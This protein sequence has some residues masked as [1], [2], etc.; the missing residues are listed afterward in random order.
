M[1]AA[2]GKKVADRRLR[3]RGRRAP[4]SASRRLIRQHQAAE[5][6]WSQ[7]VKESLG[8]GALVSDDGSFQ[9][10]RQPRSPTKLAS[11]SN[12][13]TPKARS[14]AGCVDTVEHCADAASRNV[15]SIGYGASLLVTPKI[16]TRL[17]TK[18]RSMRQA[19]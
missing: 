13:Q 16:G 4:A 7:A 11:C 9:H 15:N 2:Q 18:R 1:R 5:E 3:D 10:N 19:L 14:Y 12:D 17:P 8:S 6:R